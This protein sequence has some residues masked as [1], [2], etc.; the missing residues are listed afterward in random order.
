[1]TI[2]SKIDKE[3]IITIIAIIIAV[4]LISFVFYRYVVGSTSN[5]QN[6]TGGVQT[7]IKIK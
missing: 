4:I 2:F 5:V 6:I 3:I 7:E 1:M